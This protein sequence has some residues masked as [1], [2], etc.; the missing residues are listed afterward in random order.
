VN[1]QNTEGRPGVAG[2]ALQC[3]AASLSQF[4]Q[5]HA[6]PSSKTLARLAVALRVPVAFFAAPMRSDPSGVTNGFFRSLRSTAPRERRRALAYVELTREIARQRE[7]FVRLPVLDIPQFQGRVTDGTSGEA[8]EEIAATVRAKWQMPPGRVDD[9]VIQLE[10]HGIVTTRFNVGHAKID[11]FSVPFA[12][13]PVVVLGADKNLRDRSRFDA[14]HE[15]AH[16]VLHREDQIGSKTI[17]A[18]AHQFAAAFLMPAV[19]IRS[20]LPSRPHWATLLRLKAYWHVSIA[21]LLKRAVTVRVMEQ[22]THVQAL[23]TMSTQGWRQQE[24]GDLGQPECPVLLRRAVDVA[25]SVGVT[26]TDL[27]QRAG[28]PEVEVRAIIGSASDDRPAVEI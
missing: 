21:A 14:A 17:E 19:D 27:A 12:D 26:L 25:A 7:A 22:S 24:P 4:E 23:K 1:R 3:V 11:A 9:M 18:Q 28:L 15:L 16:L 10:R 6:K 5:G 2:L 20:Q 13:R 8:I